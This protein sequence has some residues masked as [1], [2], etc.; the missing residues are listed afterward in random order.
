MG[1]NMA[2]E[3][4]RVEFSFGKLGCGGFGQLRYVELCQVNV[5]RVEA[6]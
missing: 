6:V 1:Q 5:R 3:V 4:S 2:V